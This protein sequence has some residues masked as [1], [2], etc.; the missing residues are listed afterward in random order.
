MTSFIKGSDRTLHLKPLHKSIEE[1][2]ENEYQD[3]VALLSIDEDGKEISITYG[4]LNCDSNRIGRFLLKTVSD[5]DLKPNQDGDWAVC[6]CM[7]PSDSFVK[8]MMGIL[9]S[10]GK[11]KL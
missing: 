8:V 6:V 2:S 4:E 10:G 1:L 5:N 11:I 9:K 3:K 7:K